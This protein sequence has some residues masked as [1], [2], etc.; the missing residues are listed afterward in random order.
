MPHVINN[1][2]A[3]Q[4]TKLGWAK[5]IVFLPPARVIHFENNF[6][7]M[8]QKNFQVSSVDKMEDMINS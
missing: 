3:N 4:Q 8:W 6:E 5:I 2:Y 7:F 1:I